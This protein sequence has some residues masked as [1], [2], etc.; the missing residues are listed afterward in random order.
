MLNNTK[1]LFTINN[2][3]L[4]KIGLDIGGSLTNI[5][6]ALAKREEYESI[7]N[8]FKLKFSFLEEIEIEDNFLY[9]GLFQTNKF[10]ID[11]IEFLNSILIIFTI[12][13]IK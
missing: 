5:A 3:G 2:S 11:I 8:Q 6:V 4:L 1:G 9:I 13:R 7:R 12:N 10:N